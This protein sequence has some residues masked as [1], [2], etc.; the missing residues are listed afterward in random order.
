MTPKEEYARVVLVNI[1]DE[2]TW[3]IKIEDFEL[4]GPYR[5][6]L[7][8]EKKCDGFNRNLSKVAVPKSENEKLKNRLRHAESDRV[9]LA[10]ERD[11]IKAKMKAWVYAVEE[12]ALDPRIMDGF[13][14]V[15]KDGKPWAVPP[16]SIKPVF[17]KLKQHMDNLLPGIRKSMRE[18]E[19][20]VYRLKEKHDRLLEA[21]KKALYYLDQRFYDYFG[22]KTEQEDV[23]S[24]RRELK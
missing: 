21:A 11:E 15:L 16:D 8:A 22:I 7:I 23:E 5:V 19:N 10:E 2:P 4:G 18:D 12:M 1:D 6:F 3:F 13:F 9:R 17:E 24:L 20:N 14:V